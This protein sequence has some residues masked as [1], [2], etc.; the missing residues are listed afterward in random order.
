MDSE[1]REYFD[2]QL[3]QVLQE[4]PQRVHD[5]LD[6][7][8]LHVEDYPS[9]QVMAELGIRDRGALCG[10]YT[11]VPIDQRS[12]TAPPLLPDVVTIYREG[13]LNLASDHGG[14]V[15]TDQLRRQIRITVLHEL[16]HHHGM[17]EDELIQFGYG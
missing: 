1:L 13:I 15:D 11:G 8:P 4:L 2:Q 12:A 6:H 17:D 10:L 16:G 7:M 5:L 3:Q 14:R 9:S